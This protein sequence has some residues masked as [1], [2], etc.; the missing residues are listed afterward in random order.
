MGVG[1]S[2]QS[3][4]V[5]QFLR[6][7]DRVD[8]QLDNMSNSSFELAILS[9]VPGSINML[10]YLIPVLYLKENQ[11]T[12]VYHKQ[13]NLK[14]FDQGVTIKSSLHTFGSFI[15][16]VK[17]HIHTPSDKFYMQKFWYWTLAEGLCR[18]CKNIWFNFE[19]QMFFQRKALKYHRSF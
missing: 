13:S 3:I 2:S 17:L 18:S 16:G 9:M 6:K 5:L 14:C 8:N 1:V 4:R 12:K 7:G 11:T 10:S 15:V 19:P